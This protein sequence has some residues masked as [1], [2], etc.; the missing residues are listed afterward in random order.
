LNTDPDKRFGVDAIRR[1][2][3]CRANSQRVLSGIIIGY[4]TIPIDDNILQRMEQ[5]FVIDQ[6][7]AIRCLEANNHNHITTTYYLL[8]KQLVS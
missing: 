2:S 4:E 5:E 1:H 8:L 3:W 7:T 6:A